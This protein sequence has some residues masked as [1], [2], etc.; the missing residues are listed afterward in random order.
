[1]LDDTG[2]SDAGSRDPIDT[3]RAIKARH[4]RHTNVRPG[5]G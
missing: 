3:L 5:G 4:A 1:M 2:R